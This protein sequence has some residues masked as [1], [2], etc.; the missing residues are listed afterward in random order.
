MAARLRPVDSATRY[1]DYLQVDVGDA[2]DQLAHSVKSRWVGEGAK[3]L[4]H[5]GPVEPRA[6][7]AVLR[8]WVPGG[9]QRGRRHK[10]RRLGRRRSGKWEHRPGLDLT[11]SPPKSVSILA[12]LGNDGWLMAAH[13]GAARRTL[14]RIESEYVETRKSDPKTRRTVRVGG[15]KMVAATF[16]HVRSR[17]LDPHI[18]T[19][20]IIANAVLGDDGKWRT[21]ANEK[22]YTGAGESTRSTSRSLPGNSS[23]LDTDS[24]RRIRTAASRSRAYRTR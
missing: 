7:S 18:H 14:E 2:R 4:G 16:L 10:P 17:E 8:G 13:E 3:F 9:S 21:M 23:P 12:L 22:I 5:T 15:Q 24:G 1:V 19:H 11:L 20:S 6:L